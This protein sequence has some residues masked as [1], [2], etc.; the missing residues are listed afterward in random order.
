MA[1]RSDWN[2]CCQLDVLPAGLS[3]G[4]DQL[5]RG[6]DDLLIVRRHEPVLLGLA[7][8]A[9]AGHLDQPLIVGATSDGDQADD[10]QEPSLEDGGRRLSC[11]FLQRVNN[12]NSRRWRARRS[13]TSRTS[14][15][16]VPSKSKEQ[17]A[18]A[19][20]AVSV[21]LPLNATYDRR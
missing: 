13:R 9:L 15:T 8:E 3:I 11:R 10:Q 17:V 1:D 5:A 20:A 14:A 7:V 21:F 2:S 12:R 18:K 6:V 16:T 19:T 4:F